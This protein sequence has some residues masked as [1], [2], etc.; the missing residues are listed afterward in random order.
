MRDMP[1]PT[2]SVLLENNVWDEEGLGWESFLLCRLIRTFYDFIKLGKLK[3]L[4]T[5]TIIMGNLKFF[6]KRNLCLSFRKI[7]VDSV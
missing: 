5:L 6:L 7:V 1:H 2:N 4:L 3:I